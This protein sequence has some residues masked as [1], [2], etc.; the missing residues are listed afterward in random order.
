[1]LTMLFGAIWTLFLRDLVFSS[2]RSLFNASLLVFNILHLRCCRLYF[3]WFSSI[4][5]FVLQASTSWILHSFI[6]EGAEHPWFRLFIFGRCPPPSASDTMFHLVALVGT[7]VM[8]HKTSRAVRK[9][10]GT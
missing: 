8:P 5:F 1:M 4:S 3:H 9:D 10:I 7:P 6:G 2:L